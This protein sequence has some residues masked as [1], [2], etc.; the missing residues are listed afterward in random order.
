MEGQHFLVGNK[1]FNNYFAAIR[2]SKTTGLFAEGVL[3]QWHIDAW[4]KVDVQETMS[5]PI[6]HWFDQKLRWIADTYKVKRLNYSGGTD[7]H[8]LLL[9]ANQLGIVFDSVW[10]YFTATK[11]DEIK[12]VDGETCPGLDFVK[13]HPKMYKNLELGFC[14]VDMYENWLD[15]NFPYREPG[16]HMGFRVSERNVIMQN[17]WVDADCEITGQAKPLLYKKENKWYMVW[18]SGFDQPAHLK[19]IQYFYSDGYVPEVA[20]AQAYHAKNWIEKNLKPRNGWY[21]G[22]HFMEPKNVIS[23]NQIIGRAPALNEDILHARFGKGGPHNG[24]HTEAMHLISNKGRWDI[25]EGYMARCEEVIADLQDVH[26]GIDIQETNKSMYPRNHNKFYEKFL[27]PRFIDR[28]L[29]VLEM[30][31]EYLVSVDDSVLN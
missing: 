1:K 23:Y 11:E 24:K 25:I 27:V 3:P 17:C 5:K 26:Y 2:E 19:G 14:T 28:I 12:H 8:T 10:M 30:Q 4:A 15:K 22:I 31:D 13:A 29:A 7:S 18:L 16:L 20:V 9:R 21:S 6:H